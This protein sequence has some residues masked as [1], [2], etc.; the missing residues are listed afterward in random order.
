MAGIGG[1]VAA[2]Q[3]DFGRLL[4]YAALSDL[5]YLLLSLVMGGSQSQVLAMLHMI[6][7]A[8][9]IA[10][11]AG[12]L[13]IIRHSTKTDRFASLQGMA[14]RLPVATLG[15]MLGYLALAGFPLTAGFPTRWAVGRA[16][17][18]WALPFSPL[19]QGSGEFVGIT[20]GEP[21]AG[22]LVILAVAIGSTGAV[23]GALRG[24]SAMLGSGRDDAVRQ[25]VIASFM[26]LVLAGLVILLG[27]YPQ[28]FLKPILTA[29]EALTSF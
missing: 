5:G 2:A 18:N 27:L 10:L 29:A 7:R 6:S 23:I 17:W 11:V 9:S 28:L 1:F 26:V 19:A 14:R 4:G 12:A 16:V 20:S 24:L 3:R 25:P 15:L 13:S 21:W 8:L 22:G